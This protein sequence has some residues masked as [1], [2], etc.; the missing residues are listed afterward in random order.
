MDKFHTAFRQHALLSTHVN[1]AE[2]LR[3]T[4]RKKTFDKQLDIGRCPCCFVF[5][6]RNEFPVPEMAL[7][8]GRQLEECEAYIEACVAKAAPLDQVSAVPLSSA[9]SIPGFLGASPDVPAVADQWCAHQT[10]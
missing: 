2:K 6:A 1:L 3:Q 7:V 5:A 9:P 10:I 4:T 8:E